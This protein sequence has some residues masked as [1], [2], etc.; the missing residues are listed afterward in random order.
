MK[1][2]QKNKFRVHKKIIIIL[3]IHLI[4]FIAIQE[5]NQNNQFQLIR[6]EKNKQNLINFL[7]V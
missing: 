4:D 3:E 2:R 7:K 6:V 5:H 1:K